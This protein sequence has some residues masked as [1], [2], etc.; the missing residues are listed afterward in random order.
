[1]VK[2]FYPGTLSL[3]V[4]ETEKAHRAL[5][6]RAAA[7]GMVLLENN[8]VLPLRR[9]SKVALYGYGARYTVKGGTGS[10]A[11]NNRG[12]VSIDEGLR[13]AGF[14][15]C[16]DQWLDD[17]DKRYQKARK[18]WEEGILAR[19]GKP[20]DF[21][22]L[23]YEHSSN[24]LQAPLGAPITRAEAD[25][26]IYVVSRISGEGADRKARKGDYYLSDAET[27]TL[28]TITSLYRNTVLVLNVGGVMDL[29]FLDSVKVSAVVLM[30]QAGMEGGNALADVLSG[31]VN[32]CGHLTDTWALSYGDYPGS[33]DFSHNNG[34][35]YE[36]KYSEGIYV[37]Y[38]YFDTFSVPCR[39]PLGYGLSYT[40]FGLAWGAPEKDTEIRV[41]VTVTNTGKY[42]GREVVQ[43]YCSCPVGRYP[44][45][46]RRLVG[47][48][49]TQLLEPGQ[50]QRLV[51]SFPV[52][53][54]ESW[55]T[56]KGS[57][58]MEAGAYY[59]FGGPNLGAL[60]LCGVLTLHEQRWIQK[61]HNICPL[62]DCLKELQPT[63][64][65]MQTWRAG[66]AEQ[67]AG[68]PELSIDGLVVSRPTPDYAARPTGSDDAEIRNDPV[69]GRLSVEEKAKLCCG[70]LRTAA[71]DFIGSAA[72]TVPGAAGETTWD[73]EK[74]HGIGHLVMADGPA[75]IRLTQKY[76]VGDD[77]MPM[78][79]GGVEKLLNRCFGHEFLQEGRQVHYQ[80]CTAIPIGTLLAQTYDGALLQEVGAMIAREMEQF[81]IRLWLAPGLNIHR[82][83]LCGRNF[84]YFSEDPLISGFAAAEITRGVQSV[85][86]CGTTIKHFACNNQEENRMGVTATVSERALRE[87][88]LK[89]FEY[90]VRWAQP[91][92]LMTS[93]NKINGVHTA[94][95]YD[96]C[97]RVARLEWGFDGIIMTDWT[98]TNGHGAS[99]A[100]CM[101][102]GN[103]LVM[104][105]TVGDLMEIV[106]AVFGSRDQNLDEHFLDAC[107]HRM[108]KLLKE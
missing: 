84:E 35:L 71:A 30:S 97:T 11:V 82:N 1:M 31:S 18:D 45:E 106:D 21:F 62:L 76:Q 41:P 57:F 56:G 100:K 80:F 33:A 43:L 34:N 16:T 104:P 26:A 6:R 9:G 50:S 63:T 77:G 48:A 2:P 51:I 17:Y 19:S 8:G 107:A 4:T 13:A 54:L 36:E 66:F 93:Y 59:L 49:K 60:T 15:V 10:G 53:M 38:R 81:H 90:A 65:A 74:P 91:M 22:R 28:E 85:G 24:P 92:A 58:Y 94:N 12:N 37:G 42:P 72:V 29:S 61:L 87:I 46:K 23:Y 86:S 98:T 40:T 20:L 99:A 14:T 78:D 25:T 75:G 3:E 89:G 73:L 55:H 70:R 39:Y 83:P 27:E 95:S 101:A 5:S 7:Q 105:G 69:L 103:D 88:Y 68:V 64:E 79:L 96:L 102:A 32:P 44:K 108:L 47:F 52:T 67:A